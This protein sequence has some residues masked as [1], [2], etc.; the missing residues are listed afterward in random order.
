MSREKMFNR[1]FA[2]LEN[3]EL[4]TLVEGL[5][6]ELSMQF[7]IPAKALTKKKGVGDLRG[8]WSVKFDIQGFPN[9]F[10]LVYT[11]FPSDLFPKIL[12]LIAVGPRYDHQ[13]YR[14]AAIRYRA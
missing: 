5:I 4:K 11:Y 8:L 2:A 3:N 1:D 10:R 14:Q 6:W 9:R 13:V 12:H 7:P